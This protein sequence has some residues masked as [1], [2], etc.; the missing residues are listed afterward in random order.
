[1]PPGEE[2]WEYMAPWE[3]MLPKLKV[4]DRLSKFIPPELTPITTSLSAELHPPE[5]NVNFEKL[6]GNYE[7]MI[8]N[9]PIN[10]M[11]KR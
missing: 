3:L 7:K 4:F 5:I 9:D 6:Y 11:F 1:M 2:C 8:E 10:S